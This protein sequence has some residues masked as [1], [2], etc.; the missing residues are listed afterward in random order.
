MYLNVEKTLRKHKEPITRYEKCQTAQA[1]QNLINFVD[2]RRR[3]KGTL[4]KPHRGPA[5]G[6][7]R[8]F[9]PVDLK[10]HK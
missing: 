3:W 9:K 8:L 7:P 2:L 6:I 5:T 4:G 1:F 10:T